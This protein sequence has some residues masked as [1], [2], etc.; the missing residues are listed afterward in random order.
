MKPNPV[1][2][3]LGFDADDRMV[4]IHADDIGICQATVSAYADLL[5]FGLISSAAT[6]A[7][8]PWFP[9]LADLCRRHPEV[10]MGVHLTLTSEYDALRWGPVSTRDPSTGLIDSEGYFHRRSEQVQEQ[11]DAAAVQVELDAQVRR[12]LAAGID[13]T[14]V[15]THMGSVAHPKFVAAYVQLGLQHRLPF[16]MLRLD[17]D[18]WR[19][20]GFD[21]E[22]ASLAVSF[23]QQMEDQGQPL[24]D[25]L[26]MLPLD[27]ASDWPLGE[28]VQLAKKVLGSLPPGMTHFI[29][30]PAQDTPELRAAATQSWPAR[31]AD[32]RAFT[33]D[34]LRDY[35]RDCGLHIIGYRA[36]RDLLR[37]APP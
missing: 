13:V 19:R 3:R 15:D 10:D 12:A 30:H 14:H 23:V 26:A 32:Y 29:I 34:E 20:M 7:P 25:H 21:G 31:V 11:G 37:D 16:M 17:A 18:G 6:M 4:I 9:L 8:C 24:I 33:S 2:S 1:L 28:R 35:V 27:Q 22:M 36:L 5:E